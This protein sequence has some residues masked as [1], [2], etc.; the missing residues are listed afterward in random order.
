MRLVFARHR[1]LSRRNQLLQGRP[2]P[3]AVTANAVS[4]YCRWAG[5]AAANSGN[6]K[7]TTQRH[8]RTLHKPQQLD[9]QHPHTT[10]TDLKLFLEASVH[11][12]VLSSYH[13]A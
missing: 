3:P 8:H 2:S 13:L 6:T 9:T 1:H 7:T 5:L 10:L 4:A 11:G 12:N